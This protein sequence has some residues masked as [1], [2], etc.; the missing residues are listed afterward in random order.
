M[1]TIGWTFSLDGKPH[2]V[3]LD[4]GW[5]L[6]RRIVRLD[7]KVLEHTATVRHAL[8]DRGSRHQFHIGPHACE[9]CIESNWAGL[10]RYVLMVEGRALAPTTPIPSQAFMMLNTA[11]LGIVLGLLAVGLVH[12]VRVAM[13]W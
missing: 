2:T 12:A 1:P 4:H 6:G 9:M 8:L 7:G 10:F 5:L 13:G 11:F 3:E